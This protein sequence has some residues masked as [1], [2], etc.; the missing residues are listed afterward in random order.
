MSIVTPDS[1]VAD[2]YSTLIFALGLDKGSALL[3]KEGVGGI[4]VTDSHQ[5]FVTPDLRDAFTLTSTD[6]SLMKGR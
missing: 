5:V 6:Y 3:Q 4:F 2:G 1:M